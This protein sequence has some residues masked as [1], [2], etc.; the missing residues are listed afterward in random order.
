MVCYSFN[1][2]FLQRRILCVFICVVF[3]WS[4]EE[5]RNMGAWN[6]VHPRLENMCGRKVRRPQ[7]NKVIVN[8]YIPFLQIKYYGRYE[9]ATPAVGVSAWHKVEAADIVS[10]PFN[11]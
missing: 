4:Q 7:S 3:I 9:A 11:L 5:H 10:G 2:H 8:C 6:F 1:E